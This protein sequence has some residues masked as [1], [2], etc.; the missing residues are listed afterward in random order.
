M[1]LLLELAQSLSFTLGVIAIAL[2]VV[3]FEVGRRMVKASEMAADAID[4][5]A[6]SLEGASEGGEVAMVDLR[7]SSA[8]API[9]SSFRQVGRLLGQML[10]GKRPRY[11]VPWF[12]CVGP[13]AAGKTTL[14]GHNRLVLP[15]GDPDEASGTS[16]SGY[17]WWL[18]DRAVA[19]DTAGDFVLQSTGT[20]SDQASWKSYLKLL[21]RD[22]PR[23][24]ADGAVLTIPATDLLAYEATDPEAQTAVAE[25]ASVLR[26]KLW[27]AQEQLRMQLPIYL[28]VTK[29]DLVPGF[30]DFVD[31]LNDDKRRQIFGWST[32]DP[33]E[34]P[35]A[36]GWVE[37]AF[38]SVE[39]DLRGKRVFL[40]LPA[41]S[42]A[43]WDRPRA[44]PA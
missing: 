41:S 14:L 43:P 33:P 16:S 18:F 37:T 22:R 40:V 1:S 29:C 23:R 2:L 9:R 17:N 38:A 35:Y 28:L 20:S 44:R 12:L 36:R 11:Q 26:R 7:S 31:L 8:H 30:G 39:G 21:K 10:P 27:A 42:C 19:L 32:A 6:S 13:V 34:T 25:R 4:D 24:P 5:D 3:L 15:L